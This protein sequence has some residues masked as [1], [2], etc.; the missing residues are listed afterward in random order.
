MIKFPIKGMMTIGFDVTHNTKDRS[1]SYGAFVATMDLNVCPKYFSA[2]SAH[3]NGEEMSSNIELHVIKA[4]KAYREQHGTLPERIFFYRDGVGDG[5]IEY[6]HSQEVTKLA[7]K[8][9]EIY[10][11]VGD[12]SLAPKFSFIIVN[13]RL[14]TRIFKGTNSVKNPNSGTVVDNT[15]TLPER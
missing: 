1:K 12:G 15:I 14:N 6:V 13:K 2:V 3:Q 8:L 7:M 10:S 11:N 5:Q 9:R 4:M